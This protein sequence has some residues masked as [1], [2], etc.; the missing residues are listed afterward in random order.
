MN[1]KSIAIEATN[2]QFSALGGTIFF[3]NLLSKLNLENDLADLLPKSGRKQFQKLKSLLLGFIC[4]LDS[5]DDI[6]KLREDR[7]FST[8][9]DGACADSTLGD[10]LRSFSSYQIE[11]LNNFL[12][13]LAMNLKTIHFANE[14]F[15]IY[16]S[17]STPNEQSGQKMEGLG[18][19][20]KKQWGLDTLAIYDHQGFHYGID[21]R[22][23]GT[24]SSNGTLISRESPLHIS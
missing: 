11:K 2:K 13:K 14:N 18:W 20:Y 1:L 19:N 5:I 21:I 10:F 24:Y 15:V 6:S 4:G 8:L 9:T 3:D 23:G 7:L 16:S 22:A 12:M 17:D